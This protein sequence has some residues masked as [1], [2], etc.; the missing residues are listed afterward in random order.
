MGTVKYDMN[1]VFEKHQ[2]KPKD[3][4]QGHPFF[5]LFSVVRSTQ[6]FAFSKKKS[7]T[8]GNEGNDTL[9]QTMFTLI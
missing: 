9:F 8:E 2:N 4:V 7:Y 6:I 5:S 1:D 3:P